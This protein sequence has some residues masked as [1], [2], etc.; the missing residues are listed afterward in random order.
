[1]RGRLKKIGKFFL[2]GCV[3]LAAIGLSA[4]FIWKYSGSGQWEL[5]ENKNGIKLYSLK[6]PG[7]TVEQFK[8]IVRVRTT[9]TTVMAASQDPSICDYGCSESKMFERVSERSQYYI[10]R[11]NYPFFFFRQREMVI[12]QRFSRIPET[13][14]L[15]VEVIAAPEKLPPNKCCVRIEFMHNTWRYTP[16]KNSELEL[17]YVMNMDDGGY[18]PYVLANLGS[19][20]FIREILAQMQSTFDKEQKKFP[21]AKFELLAEK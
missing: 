15:F 4:H 18:F 11:F 9:L 3:S 7:S 13:K 19:P 2:I 14:G 16:L 20:E 8:G 5:V 21:N 17:E 1:M 6:A 12:E 10:F